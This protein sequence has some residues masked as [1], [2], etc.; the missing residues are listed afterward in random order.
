MCILFLIFPALN[1]TARIMNYD[2]KLNN[3]L[4]SITLVSLISLALATGLLCNKGKI[5]PNKLTK[6][7]AAFALPL[8]LICAVFFVSNAMENAS[9]LFGIFILI[10]ILSAFS[11]F[12]FYPKNLA[13]KITLGVISFLI[14]LYLGVIVLLNGF[15]SNTV[16]KTLNSPDNTYTAEIIDNDQGALGGST[17]VQIQYNNKN[18]TVLF[19]EFIKHPKSIYYGEWGEFDSMN[20]KWENEYTLLINNV[21]Y[22]ITV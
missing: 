19:G 14:L 1:L 5:I 15:G 20:L 18:L 8:S 17:L 4:E 12:L 21:P 2:F 3:D 7:F 11:I 13:L 9:F 22:N 6:I 10:T 16:V